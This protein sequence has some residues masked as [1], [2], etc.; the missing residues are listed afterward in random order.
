MGKM[1]AQDQTAPA[2][3]PLRLPRWVHV[4]LIGR[5]WRFTLARLA[6]LV[7]VCFVV[8]RFI[9]VPIRVQGISMLPT[10]R[11]GSIAIVNRLAYLWHP[12]RRGDV[13][14][15]RLSPPGLA[16]PSIMYLKR[17]IGLPGETVAFVHGHALINGHALAESYVKYRCDWNLPPVK[18]GP[19]QYYIVGDNRSLPPGELV[20]GK[21]ERKYIVGKV[22]L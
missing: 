13:V 2:T 21:V 16:P 22:I 5:N 7:A 14:A 20:H 10:Y 3:L 15:I 1:S 17:I 6:V 18:L 12:P 19:N 9:L 8:F 11:T 4:I